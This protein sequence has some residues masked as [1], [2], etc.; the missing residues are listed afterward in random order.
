[1][2]L[3]R[4]PSACGALQ[5]CLG[6]EVARPARVEKDPQGR[7]YLAAEAASSAEVTLRPRTPIRT[8]DSGGAARPA[9]FVIL[10]APELRHLSAELC[11]FVC[12]PPQRVAVYL[13]L[14]ITG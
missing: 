11:R 13:Q 2:V 12:G 14:T 1:M 4:Y 6:A 3:F 8:G 5:K 9:C 7:L 10:S